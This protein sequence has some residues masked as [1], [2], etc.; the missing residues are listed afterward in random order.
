MFRLRYLDI[1]TKIILV[2]VA[3]VVPTFALVTFVQYRVTQPI[4]EQEWLK[5]GI[6]TAESVGVKA[7][8]N[9]WL[10]RPNQWKFIENEIQMQIYLQ[11]SIN[12]LDVYAKEPET[13]VLRLVGTNLEEEPGAVI[14]P[15]PEVENVTSEFLPGDDGTPVWDIRV[16]I[17]RLGPYVKGHGKIVGMVH[18]V[19]STKGI[20]RLM[21]TLWPITAIAAGISVLFLILVLSFFLRRTVQHEKLLRLAENR[22]LEL[23]EQL[24][25]A[26]RQLMNVEKLAVMGQLTANFAHEIGTPLNAI[27]GHLQLLG[28]GTKSPEE[29][30][31]IIQGELS[32]IEGIVKGFLQTTAKPVSQTQLVDLNQLVDKTLEILRPRMEGMGV[33]IRTQLDRK[34]GPVRVVPLEVQQI[35]LNLVN[36]SLDS[37]KSK[38]ESNPSSRLQ[39]TVSSGVARA[40]GQEV[41][42]V[43]VYDTGLGIRK[44]DLKNVTKPF[45]TTKAPGEGTGLGLTISQQIAAKYGGSLVVRAK[46]GAW[47]EVKIQI[48]YRESGA[49]SA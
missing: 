4:L 11:P 15:P 22:N 21:S 17:R 19:I 9:R 24:H 8:S 14:A 37:L 23:S 30:L 18:T 16:P 1:Q 6:A 3:V 46:E 43:T 26:E 49:V 7:V 42:Q 40:D 10:T 12:R 34:M 32:R 35:L 38:T 45:F 27:G 44:Q 39:L 2:L 28:K 20:V 13:G 41:A 48:P 29:R 31:G 25:E 33:E 5:I 47:A 36:N